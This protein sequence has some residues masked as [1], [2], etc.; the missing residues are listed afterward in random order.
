ME[1]VI[2]D[3]MTLTYYIKNHIRSQKN[4]DEVIQFQIFSKFAIAFYNR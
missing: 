4:N 1:D 2:G 3:C